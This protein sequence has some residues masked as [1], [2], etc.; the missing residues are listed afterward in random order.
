MKY[1]SPAGNPH[2]VGRETYWRRLEEI[3]AEEAA[4]IIVVYGR[5]RVGKTELIEQFFRGRPLLKFEGIQPDRVGV[6]RGSPVER[7]RQI[8]EC[9]KR[10]G[11]YLQRPR[12]HANMAIETWSD[13]FRLL[14]PVLEKRPIVLYL[15]EVQWMANYSD[16]LLAE[17][18]PFWDDVLRHNPHLR[19]VLSGSSPSFIVNQFLSSSALY[20]RSNHMMKLEPF[21]LHETALLLGKGA[22]ETLLAAIAVGG[23]PEYLKQVKA[24]TS[25][26]VSLCEKSF[27]PG[28][29]FRVEKDRVFVSSLAANRFY[30]GIID[31]L[32][33]RGPS[34]RR[35]LY[36]AL[37]REHTGTAGGSFSRVLDELVELDLVERLLPVT[38]ASTISNPSRSH[39][40][41]YVLADEYLRFYYTFIEPRK[42]DI[43]NG[44]YARNPVA[45]LN[46]LDFSQAMGLSFERWCRRNEQLIARHLR[47]EGV[48]E[49]AH[50]P[51]YKPGATQIDLMFIRKDFKIIIC[52]IKYN[53]DTRLRRQVILDAQEKVDVFLENNPRYARHTIETALITI[54]PVPDALQN[55]GYFTYLI[56]SDQLLA[57]AARGD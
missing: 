40:A 43:D 38:K 24:G 57:T 34:S 25:V 11:H 37:S 49:Y 5:R 14:L 42:S 29:F 21:E 16:E 17:L 31:H 50:G 1:Y 55:E 4:A 6:R 26:Y 36:K 32:A 23:V 56:T 27:L 13:F 54:E 53:S 7:R 33:R 9:V 44:K 8:A 10:L 39:H 28:G 19:V 35:E 45:A 22:R 47:F 41:R 2:F 3:D 51:W 12:A 48:V 46:R 52:E 15:D 30:E 18:K 20:N